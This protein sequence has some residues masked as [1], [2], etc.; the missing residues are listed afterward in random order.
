MLISLFSLTVFFTS[1]E[2]DNWF[3]KQYAVKKENVPAAAVILG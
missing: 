3:Q 1:S 2:A